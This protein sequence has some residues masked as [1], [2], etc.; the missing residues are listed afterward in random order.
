MTWLGFSIPSFL[1]LYK[2]L[3]LDIHLNQ[4]CR[5]WNRMSLGPSSSKMG[6][7][8]STNMSLYVTTWV[9]VHLAQKRLNS[10]LVWVQRT[11]HWTWDCPLCVQLLHAELLYCWLI[12]LEGWKVALSLK[13]V[14]STSCSERT[15]Q[16]NY[17]ADFL[18]WFLTVHWF[19]MRNMTNK[20]VYSNANLFYYKQC[21]LVHVLATQLSTNNII[22]ILY[23][24][25]DFELLF[26]T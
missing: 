9:T 25:I 11:R 14:L 16:L 13:T 10:F 4:S 3:I 17:I 1:F 18:K 20:Y 5:G 12:F 2:L 24:N 23:F 22:I 19:I 15:S 6:V 26:K 8:N 21:S 7:E